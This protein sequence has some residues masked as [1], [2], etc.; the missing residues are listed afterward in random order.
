MKNRRAQI[1]IYIILAILIVVVIVL[2]FF[3]LS[4]RKIIPPDTPSFEEPV[5]YIQKC[6]KDNVQDAVAIMLPQGG[7]IDSGSRVSKL[8][9]DINRTYL[10][11][12][13][14]NY[15]TCITQDPMYISS[16]EKEITNYINSR[17]NRCFDSLKQELE[18]SNYNVDMG[19]LE[20][21][22]KLLTG[23]IRIEIDKEFTMTKN[24]ATK[25]FRDFDTEIKSKLYDIAI[26]AQE[27]A[28]QE[29]KFCNFEYQGFM[30]FYPDFDIEKFVTSEGIKIYSIRH[31]KTNE[32]LVFAIRSCVIPPGLG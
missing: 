31:K 21:S 30:I 18:R 4:E 17:V 15:R 32:E 26:V 7:Y 1:T 29:A 10:C 14:N 13:L 24:E 25:K 22:T 3:L 2:L 20:I 19:K 28:S 12:T 5:P 11:Y 27:V 6:I 23:R 16:L 8:Y 9:K